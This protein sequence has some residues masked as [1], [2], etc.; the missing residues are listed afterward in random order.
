MTSVSPAAG[1]APSNVQQGDMGASALPSVSCNGGQNV[2]MCGA[3]R[4]ASIALGRSYH[5]RLGHVA[6]APVG[7]APRPAALAQVLQRVASG[8][9]QQQAAAQAHGSC[10]SSPARF[11]SLLAPF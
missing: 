11:G 9:A 5:Q 3:W 6:M 10:L 8:L 1:L 2:C 4:W 7:R